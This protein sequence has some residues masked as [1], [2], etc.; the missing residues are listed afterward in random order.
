MP[1]LPETVYQSGPVNVMRRV[2]APILALGLALGCRDATSPEVLAF[3]PRTS[4]WLPDPSGLILHGY[5]SGLV[6]AAD[7]VIADSQSWA[8]AWTQL[9]RGVGPPPA[10]PAVDFRTEQ[11]VL[12][13]LGQR[14]TGGYDIRIDSVVQFQRA[15]VAYVTATAPGQN[16]VTTSAL[17][18]PVDLIRLS[19]KVEPIVFQQRLVVQDCS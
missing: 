7:L 3:G 4:V 2:L 19:P 5:Y 8:T 14:R 15:S 12:V 18:Q 6:N 16:C 13:A 11:V 9:T 17:S 1:H 10:L